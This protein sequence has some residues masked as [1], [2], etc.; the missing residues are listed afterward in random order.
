MALDASK[1]VL[2]YLRRKNFRN[3]ESAFRDDAKLESLEEMTFRLK[4]LSDASVSNY[5]L[6][7]NAEEGPDR[8][9]ESYNHLRRWVEQSLDRFKVGVSLGFL[10]FPFGRL[11][12][13]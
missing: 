11:C 9:D 1:V 10:T 4:A 3:A 8:Y 2:A 5:I 7:H 13:G 12:S 6:F